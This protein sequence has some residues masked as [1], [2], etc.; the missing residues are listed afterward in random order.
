LTVNKPDVEGSLALVVPSMEMV[1]LSASWM[2]TVSDP[3]ALIDGLSVA[4]RV[5]TTVWVPSTRVSVNASTSMVVVD[6][7]ARMIA[8]PVNGSP[9]PKDV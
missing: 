7:F 9:L 3:P 2:L 4:V 8:V 1:P 6:V 5:R